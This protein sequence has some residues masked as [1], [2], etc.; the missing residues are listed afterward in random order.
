MQTLWQYHLVVSI[1]LAVHGNF[2]TKDVRSIS[3]GLSFGMCAGY[4]K[5]SIN[6]TLDPLQIIALKEPNFEQK[7]YPPI[8]KAFPTTQN[9]WEDIVTTIN[10]K[11]FQTL[12][13]TVGCP[14][15]ADGGA[16]WIRV[17]WINGSKRIT[18]ENGRAIKGL[19]E[20]IEKLRQ[21]RQQYIAQI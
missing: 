20:L 10:L 16:E 9:A 2:E 13:D 18:F 3:S 1:F 4:C 15:C 21:M 5:Q 17:D 19:E 12:G 8:Q 7:S 11:I 6:M 14:D